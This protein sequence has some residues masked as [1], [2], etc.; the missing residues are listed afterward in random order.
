MPKTLEMRNP[1][2]A[3]LIGAA[4]AALITLPG[5]GYGTLW[6]NSETAYGEVA[7]E[8]LL[9]H[10]W[11][12]MHLNGA[13]WFIQPPLYFWTAALF[14]AISHVGAFALRLPSALATIAMGAVTGYAV[15]RQ[16]GLRTGIYASVV[17]STCLMQAIV[18]RL[19]IMDAMLDLSVALAVFWWF[20]GMQTGRQ[21]YFLFGSIAVSL[22]FLTKGPV[23]PVLALMIAVVFYVWNRRYEQTMLPSWRGWIGSVFAFVV[24]VSPWLLALV[25][26]TGAHA[27]AELIGHYTVGRYT[28]TI[29]NQAGP[30]W[31]Y[32]PVL[33][34]G[35][36]PWI[37]FFPSAVAYGID[38][39][40]RHS[41]DAATRDAQQ[42]LRLVFTWI[43]VPF[44]FFSFAKTKLPNYVALE[45]PALAVLVAFYFDHAVQKGRS[46]SILISAAAVPV[47][48][49]ML[50]IAIVWFSHD[51]RLTADLNVVGANLIAVGAAVFVGSL[52]TFVVLARNP[53]MC[54]GPYVLG[55]A[56]TLAVLFL[57]LLAL[58]N[59]ERFKPVP[60]LAKVIDA[61]RLPGDAVAIQNMA[62]GN[63][64]VFYTQ[65]GVYVLASPKAANSGDG[66]DPRSIIC[67]APRTWVIAP[68]RRPR[69]DPTYGRSRRVVARS[70]KADLFLYSGPRCNSGVPR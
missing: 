2:R 10:D 26:Q 61:Q 6:D 32:L 3:S 68:K 12:V 18:G 38:R 16:A 25:S 67:A 34:L 63:A 17:L 1:A 23:A 7:R 65:P 4:I 14:A 13:A 21:R 33:I 20:R 39:L 36:F 45:F 51:N 9:Y 48:I 22:G 27:V 35:F 55:G 29:E 41:D 49:A 19:A 5:L 52:I 60:P 24:L 57:A 50:A 11:I 44:V 66:R 43:V 47:T 8:I 69:I 30:V 58:P 42:M 64:L 62:G 37:A 31:Y 15:T 40:R 46:R 56:M 70:G 28:G 54:A 59:A 53:T